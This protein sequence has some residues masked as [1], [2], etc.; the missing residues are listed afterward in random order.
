MAND[1]NSKKKKKTNQYKIN[2]IPF[3]LCTDDTNSAK[4]T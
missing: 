2:I 4:S 3:L 1:I